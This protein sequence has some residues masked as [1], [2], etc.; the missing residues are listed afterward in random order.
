MLDF[1]RVLRSG[2]A[3]TLPVDRIAGARKDGDLR[4]RLGN[5]RPYWRRHWRKAALGAGL[6]L[7]VSLLSFPLP[8]LYRFLVDDVMLAR[9]LDLLPLAILLLAGVKL[10][11]V[12]GEAAQRYFFTRFEQQAILDLQQNLLDHA[13]RLP[14]SFF[15]DK[16]VGYLISRL[17]SDVQGL[18]WFFSSE[19]AYFV[20]AVFRFVGG[21]VLLFYLEW[22]LSIVTLVVLPLIVI[23]TRYFGGR[24]HAISH[25]GMERSAGITQRLEETLASL[26]L[27]KAFATEKRESERVLAEVEAAQKIELE[28]AT[29]GSLAGFFLGAAPGLASGVALILGAYWIIQGQWTVGSLLAF[30]SYLGFVFGPA[31]SLATANLQY[32]NALTALERISAILDVL[33]EETP[34][35]GRPVS[36]L[37]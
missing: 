32:Q 17:S 21:A 6:I 14:K 30:Q 11:S 22:R 1:F 28:Q 34:G 23:G 26:P 5:L 31:M 2:L 18:R 16:E 13:L 12:G 20:G 4:A 7:L 15:D 10:V 19:L 29:V 37:E 3:R 9:R 8:L 36:R 25:H 24:L 33:P 35:V 27:I